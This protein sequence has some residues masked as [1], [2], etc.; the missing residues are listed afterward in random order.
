MIQGTVNGKN[1]WWNVVK[2]KV[3]A[4]P[5]V[6]HNSN[7]WWYINNEG[8]VNF[9]YTGFAKNGNGWWYA[10]GGKVDFTKSGV[11]SGTINGVK[12]YYLVSKDHVV[13]NKGEANEK[14]VAQIGYGDIFEKQLKGSTCWVAKNMNGAK[15]GTPYRIKSL[16]KGYFYV[17]EYPR[18]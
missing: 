10:H 3:T 4:G 15:V 5:T 17:E 7:G 16:S 1:A 2:N 9:S 14:T 12:G 11:F 18:D 8:Y 13:M 6:A